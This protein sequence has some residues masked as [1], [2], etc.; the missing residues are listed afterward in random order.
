[1]WWVSYRGE[2]RHGLENIG[3]F[4]DDGKPREKHPLLLDESPDAAP[5]K[6][7]RGFAK[8]EQMLDKPGRVYFN[9]FAWARYFGD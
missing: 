6:I 9:E 7:A 1:M 2:G 3:V 8:D 4:D 5:L